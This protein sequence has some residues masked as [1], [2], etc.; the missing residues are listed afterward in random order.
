MQVEL[1]ILNDW[2]DVLA[3]DKPAGWL[4]IP[5][6][7]NKENIPIVSHVLGSQLRG[8]KDQVGKDLFI[9]HRLDE[10]TS[11]VMLFTKTSE[12]HKELSRQFLE[13]EIKKTYWALV[14]G[15]LDREM[16]IDAPIFKLPSKKNKSVVDPKGKPS[17]TSVKPLKIL[18]GFTLVEAR[19][20]TG[21]THQIRVHLAHVDFPLVGDSLYGGPAEAPGLKFDYP[22]LHAQHI[23]FQWPANSPKDVT[24]SP[25]GDFLRALMALKKGDLGL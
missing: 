21:R 13:G 23:A 10:G 11:G 20:L 18:N 16:E 25:S 17:Q 15:E 14:K 9:V 7:G 4:S 6:R 19:P 22:L 12:S 2:G 1:K 5:G 3:V 8:G 24:S